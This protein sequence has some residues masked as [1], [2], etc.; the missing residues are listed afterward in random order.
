MSKIIRRQ[1]GVTDTILHGFPKEMITLVT[2]KQGT[3][4]SLF[5][6]IPIRQKMRLFLVDTASERSYLFFLPL[7]SEAK[8]KFVELNSPDGTTSKCIETLFDGITFWYSEIR[9]MVI[10]SYEKVYNTTI[11][12]VLGLDYLLK[13]KINLDFSKII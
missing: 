13:E 5:A 3:Y 12:G 1:G 11:H 9:P 8:S 10:N 2:L 6:R 4:V 7:G